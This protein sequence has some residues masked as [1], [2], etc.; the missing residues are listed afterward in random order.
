MRNLVVVKRAIVLSINAEI[1]KKLGHRSVSLDRGEQDKHNGEEVISNRKLFGKLISCL[2]F[3]SFFA[4]DFLTELTYQYYT[5]R[6]DI[7]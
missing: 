2:Y 3:L 7:R 4:G 6:P 5:G 1:T